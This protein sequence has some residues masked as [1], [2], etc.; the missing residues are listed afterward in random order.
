MK[1]STDGCF[2]YTHEPLLQTKPDGAFSS[3]RTDLIRYQTK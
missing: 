3:E 1:I 2:E